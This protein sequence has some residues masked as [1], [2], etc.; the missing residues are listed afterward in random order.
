MKDVMIIETR[1]PT[2]ARDI[3]WTADLAA[4]MRQAGSGFLM[5][6]EN[7]VLA[8]RASVPPTCCRA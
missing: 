3:E 5:L 8:A 2:K 1:D 7:G 6:T 4:R